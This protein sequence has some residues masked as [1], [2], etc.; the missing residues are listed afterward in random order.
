MTGKRL[1]CAISCL[2]LAWVQAGAAEPEFP[3]FDLDYL[4]A[5]AQAQPTLPGEPPRDQPP[6]A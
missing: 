1:C 5:Q 6:P 2:L 4:T 3:G